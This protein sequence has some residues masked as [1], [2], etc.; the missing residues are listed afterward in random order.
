M[1]WQQK[2]DLIQQGPVTCARNFEHMVQLFTKDVLKSNVMPTGEIVHLFYT[3][4]FQQWGSPH[5]HALFWVSSCH[6]F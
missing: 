3:V 5:I 4:E 1:T 6:G 2:S